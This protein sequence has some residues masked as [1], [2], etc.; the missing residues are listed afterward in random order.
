MHPYGETILIE[1]NHELMP[2]LGNVGILI[3]I[4]SHVFVHKALL[5]IFIPQTCVISN[6]KKNALNVV[7]N[8]K[9]KVAT[10][11]IINKNLSTELKWVVF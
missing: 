9:G 1:Y 2:A 5:S 8:E 10:G 4:N 11:T 7:G 6:Y 3:R